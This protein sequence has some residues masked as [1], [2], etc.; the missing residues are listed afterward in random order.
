MDFFIFKSFI[1][2]ETAMLLS[3]FIIAFVMG[4]FVNKTNFC[5]MGAV[6][7]VI[8][9]G[10]TGRLRA[11]FFAIAIAILGVGVLEYYNLLDPSSTFPPYRNSNIAIFENLLGGLMFG[12]GMT[13]ASG[14]GNKTLVRIGGGNIKSIIVFVIVG[15]IAYYM[16]NPLPGTDQTIYSY[17]FYSWTNDLSA[18]AT[19]TQDLGSIFGGEEPATT[20]LLFSIIIALLILVYAFKS[21]DFRTLD[22]ILG[23]LV[24][25]VAVV[26]AWFMS[27]SYT[28]QPDPETPDDQYKLIEYYQD[29]DMLAD[30]SRTKPAA[31]TPLS[32][33]SFSFIN[34]MGQTINYVYNVGAEVLGVGLSDYNKEKIK[35]SAE[36]FKML[37]EEYDVCLSESES[38]EE[39]LECTKP[40]KAVFEMNNLLTFGVVAVFGVILGSFLWSLVSRSFRVEWFSSLKDVY[41]HV[42]GAI[43]MGIGGTLAMGCT[44]G[45]AVSGVST[46]AIG[47]ILTFAAIFFG[48]ALTM[49]TQ[50]YKMVYDAEATY[51]ACFVTGMVDLKLLPESFRKLEK[52]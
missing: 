39:K 47:S 31:G 28:V 41:S 16:V 14:C 49:K 36:Q 25:G 24:V 43:L 18:V 23:G 32:T 29:W 2:A 6:S 52:V 44:I 13:L 46:L 27:A 9:I 3:V 17:L 37:S 5:T 1:E 40:Y 42:I 4:L 11:W 48:S 45:Q 50:Y 19:T 15:A 7:D 38:E 26:L 51:L 12:V 34:P 10:D 21:K 30:N 33:Q 8:N 35:N 20:K 22:N